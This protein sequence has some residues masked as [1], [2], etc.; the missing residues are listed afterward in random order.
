M[1]DSYE[2]KEAPKREDRLHPCIT[3]SE[4]LRACSKKAGKQRKDYCRSA[5]RYRRKVFVNNIVY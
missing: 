4:A 5:A 2:L 3:Y 1:A